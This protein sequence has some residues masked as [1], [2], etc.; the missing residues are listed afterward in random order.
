MKQPGLL[1]FL[2]PLAA[3]ADVGCQSPRGNVGLEGVQLSSSR[4]QWNDHDNAFKHNTLLNVYGS[5]SLNCYAGEA[6]TFKGEANG[7]F[8]W[9][10]HQPGS[11][12][13]RRRQGRMF[14]NLAALSWAARENLFIDAGKIRRRYGY[15]YTVSP[16]DLLR[17]PHGAFRSVHVNAAG[18][19]WPAF[20]DEGSWGIS[21]SLLTASGSWDAVILPRLTQENTDIDADYHESSLK[22][23]NAQDRY[24]FSYST[25]G[26][27]NRTSTI[28]LL[29]G[30]QKRLSAGVNYMLNDNWV[31]NLEGGFAKGQTWRHLQK[32]A[33]QGLHS[34][35]ASATK[36]PF[37]RR[38]GGVTG[39]IGGGVRYTSSEQIES[40]VEYYGQSQGYSRSEW[41]QLTRDVAFANG[42]YINPRYPITSLPI[43]QDGFR[44][45]SR[46]MAAEIDRTGRQ[47]A[48][49]TKHY[50][51]L[52]NSR[53]RSETGALNW[54]TSAIANLTDGSVL[55]TMQVS[56]PVRDDTEIY[57]GTTL[58]F[59]R[60]GSEFSLFGEKGLYYAGLRYFW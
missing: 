42:G 34:Y 56:S 27:A 30:A 2:M 49:Q 55:T 18:D 17:N 50:L 7:E 35:D 32:E 21:A 46:L 16:L 23:T 54:R 48:L 51:M 8:I 45:Y 1:V 37:S 4:T 22:R 19:S 38:S 10:R 40:G 60:A 9:H 52:F 58:S 47:G 13:D 29:A 5:A 31:L 43:V 28:S 6:L 3:L 36:E 39:D 11:L 53:N 25:S 33:T 57:T 44:L 26:L 41:R 14:Y 59:G 24:L 12:Q 20:Y 15:L